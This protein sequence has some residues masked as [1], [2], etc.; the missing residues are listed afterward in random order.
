ML[1]KRLTRQGLS[2]SGASLSA[3]LAQEAGAAPMSTSLLGSPIPATALV[4]GGQAV[5]AGAIP[6]QV[7]ALTQGLRQQ[8]AAAPQGQQPG[9]VAREQPPP[10]RVCT[11]LRHGRQGGSGPSRRCPPGKLW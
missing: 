2:V 7:A 10:A 4:A 6:V 8:T 5:T 11:L 1:A 9:A 3:V